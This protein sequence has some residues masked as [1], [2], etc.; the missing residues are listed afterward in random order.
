MSEK[1]SWRDVYKVHPAADLFP[2]LPD[3]ELR[4][5]A[6]DIKKNGLKEKIVLWSPGLPKLDEKTKRHTNEVYLLDGRNRLAAMELCGLDAVTYHPDRIYWIPDKLGSGCVGNDAS[7]HYFELTKSYPLTFGKNAG[8]GEGKIEPAVDACAF[9]L[10][11]NVYRRHLTKEKQA[12][13]IV[14]VMKAQTDFA[15]LARSVKRDSNGHVQGS[16]KDPIKE[17]AVEEAK[18]HDISKRT[19]ERAIAKDRGPTQKPRTP[20]ERTDETDRFKKLLAHIQKSRKENRAYINRLWSPEKTQLPKLDSLIDEVEQTL[21]DQPHIEFTEK[22]LA[23]IRGKREEHRERYRNSRWNPDGVLKNERMNLLDEVERELENFINAVPRTAPKPAP[24]VPTE[25]PKQAIP[26][27]LRL[28]EMSRNE[29]YEM[30][31]SYWEK[32]NKLQEELV[33]A[34]WELITSQLTQAL[35]VNGMDM[36]PGQYKRRIWKKFHPDHNSGKTFTADEIMAE[37]NP[38]LSFLNEPPTTSN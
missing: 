33:M 16:A 11:R 1:K 26:A 9:I 31:I 18:K 28:K 23:H 6:E 37:I 35:R 15:N 21:D 12:D 8:L 2:M 4:K 5:L 10:S 24:K 25:P 27:I 30:L 34:R 32:N 36:S 3:D 29:L 13:L 7:I 38:L 20:S 22:L 19:I 17:K 14:K